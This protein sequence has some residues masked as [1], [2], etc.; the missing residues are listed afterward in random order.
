MYLAPHRQRQESPISPSVVLSRDM[1]NKKEQKTCKAAVQSGPL[2]SISQVGGFAVFHF[3][4]PFGPNKHGRTGHFWTS[5][6]LVD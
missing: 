3:I 1:P 4:T 5:G 6:W 2:F